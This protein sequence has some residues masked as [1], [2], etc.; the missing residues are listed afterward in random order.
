MQNCNHLTIIPY[1]MQKD[2]PFARL[3]LKII[4]LYL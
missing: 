3:C 1:K 2:E 4:F